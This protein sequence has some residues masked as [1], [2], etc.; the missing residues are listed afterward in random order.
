[1]LIAIIA[2]ALLSA[3]SLWSERLGTTFEASNN[4]IAGALGSGHGGNGS[5]SG[6]TTQ[7]GT[8]QAGSKPIGGGSTSGSGTSTGPEGLSGPISSDDPAAGNDAGR[9]I[10]SER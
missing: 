2:A 9:L 3:G 7:A 8:S 5:S 4:G 10:L 6:G 1:M